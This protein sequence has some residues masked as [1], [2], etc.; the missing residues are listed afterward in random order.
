MMDPDLEV[1][2][3]KGFNGAGMFLSRK[4]AL[5]MRDDVHPEM[6]QWGRDVSIPEIAARMA[7]SAPARHGFNGAGMFLSRK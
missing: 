7:I 4:F 6:L 1:W 2:V 3:R 5:A